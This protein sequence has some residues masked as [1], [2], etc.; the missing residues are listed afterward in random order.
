MATAPTAPVNQDHASRAA[1]RL[2]REVADYERRLR[3]LN[4]HESSGRQSYLIEAYRRAMRL[5]QSL[6][7]DL[8]RPPERAPDP[9]QRN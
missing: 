4:T 6:I 2:L 3:R 1:A 5:R 8:P 9:W 7:D